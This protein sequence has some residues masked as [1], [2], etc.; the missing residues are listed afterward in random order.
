SPFCSSLLEEV[1]DLYLEAAHQNGDMIDPD[2]Q[3]GLGVLFHL[4]GE[5]NRAIDAFSAA[6]TVRPED[7]TLWNRLGATLANGDRSEEAVEA[8]TRALE[9]QPGFIRS[10]YNLGI[11]CINL[12]AY[13]E[14]V[15]NFLTALSLQRKSRNQQQVP[16][17]ALSGNI[18]AALRIALSMMDQPELF[19]AANV[20]DL[21]IL[22]RA[23]NLEP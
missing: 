9:I 23:F 14:A 4:N 20:G 19:Q 22:L 3:T 17:P 13:R 8:Y 16:H 6:L 10:R 2:L 18:W 11:S 1:K 21:D 12:G 15:S 5:F 7:Y